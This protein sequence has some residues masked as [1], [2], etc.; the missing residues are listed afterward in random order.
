MRSRPPSRGQPQAQLRPA[1]AE[2]LRTC[3]HPPSLL[4]RVEQI[5]E[6]V[7][8][9]NQADGEPTARSL[10]GRSAGFRK[11][12]RLILGDGE[13]MIQGV[14]RQPLHSLLESRDFGKG[15]LL[16][17]KRFR[18]ARAKRTNGKGEV[19]YFGIEDLEIVGAT[20]SA[21]S[22]LE[23][24]LDAGGFI[25]DDDEHQ[26]PE[27]TIERKEIGGHMEQTNSGQTTLPTD[28]MPS[29]RPCQE[30]DGFENL[31]VDVAAVVQRRRILKELSN[32]KRVH[33]TA[34]ADT[35]SRKRKRLEAES[36]IKLT[37]TGSSTV[38]ATGNASPII[39]PRTQ[40]LPPLHDL[41]SLMNP[42][43]PLP[44]RNYSCSVFAVVSWISD[45]LIHKPN[46]PFP[47]KRHLKIHD[48]SISSRYA[49]IT[50]AVYVDAQRFLPKVGTVAL[51]RGLTM[52]KWDGKVI[53][54]AYASLRDG[55][56][57]WYVDSPGELLEL[58]YDADEMKTWWEDRRNRK[59]K[60]VVKGK[61]V[62]KGEEALK[63]SSD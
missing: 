28:T 8:T 14:L 17:L 55:A 58:G 50:L 2:V 62:L 24:G 52:Q 13:L 26:V 32:H 11:T 43:T 9:D 40:P 33:E 39:L 44:S 47:P 63:G 6:D 60:E 1:I 4:L 53:L 20:V 7:V 49:G 22:K 37:R 18:V 54:N 38:L 41:A 34:Q 59:G 36:C 42:P 30:S 29:P 3:V 61:E 27:F 16:E 45:F 35:K 10:V 21:Q 46:S 12:S 15:A 25:R 5:A 56:E 51:F 57:K 31:V 23:S 48:P 19:V